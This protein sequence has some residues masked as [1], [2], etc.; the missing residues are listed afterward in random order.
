METILL[1][2]ALGAVENQVGCQK[3]LWRKIFPD[4]GLTMDI[5]VEPRYSSGNWCCLKWGK[6]T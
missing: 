1:V 6:G 5:V 4:R 3:Q 2:P